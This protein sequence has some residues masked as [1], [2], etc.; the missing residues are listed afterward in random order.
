MS[1]LDIFPDELILHMCDV[2]ATNYMGMYRLNRHFHAMLK[3]CKSKMLQR[4]L[5][6]F[7]S[8]KKEPFEHTELIYGTIGDN[9]NGPYSY[10]LT[11]CVY[12]AFRG[13]IGRTQGAY[14]DN[15]K[16][17][18]WIKTHRGAIIKKCQY[19]F[20]KVITRYNYTSNGRIKNIIHYDEHENIIKVEHI[21]AKMTIH[22]NTGVIEEVAV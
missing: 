14:R 20:G 5:Q 22:C 9:R 8:V 11:S 15:A 1:L 12:Y 18:T 3:E 10:S 13:I 4:H 17:G 21:D 6:S 2:S 7:I 19:C 16:H